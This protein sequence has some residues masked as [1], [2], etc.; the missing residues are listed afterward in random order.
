MSHAEPL[1]RI[2][3]LLARQ[4]GSQP[5]A[6]CL[7]EEGGGILTYAQLWQRARDAAD[8]L[9][10][11]G[12]RPGHRVLMVGENCAA[13]IAALFGCGII[14]AWPVGVNAR[15]SAREIAAIS[16]HAQPEITLYTSG[17]SGAAA[18]HADAAG[19]QPADAAAWGPGVRARRADSPTQPETGAPAAE[20]ATVIYTSGTTG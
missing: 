12:V 8:W 16:A 3:Q 10:A 5:D 2:H 17:V 6:I 9:A 14:G 7:Y 20:V 4:A 18:A 19:A 15:L 11:A 13:M 1:T